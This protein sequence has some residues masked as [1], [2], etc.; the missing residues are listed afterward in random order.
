MNSH[1]VPNTK[2]IV[3]LGST[4][5]DPHVVP[6][7]LAKLMLE[8]N[9]YQVVNLRCFNAPE[10]FVTTAQD[11]E[12]IRAI[13]ISNNNGAACEDLEG[14]STALGRSKTR[15]PVILGGRAWLEF[16]PEI[17]RT[18][19]DHGITHIC[20]DFDALLHTLETMKGTVPC[21]TLA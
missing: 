20:K 13:V 8:E 12:D 11:H 7:F 16:T 1:V 5:S 15:I 4:S 6:L 21:H 2:G 18:L 17:E 3:V 9:G 10:T 14:L 19:H